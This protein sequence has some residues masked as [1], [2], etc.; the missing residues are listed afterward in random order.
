M[1]N[2]RRLLLGL[3]LVILIVAL[4]VTRD[5]E[6]VTPRGEGVV[7]LETGTFE[8]F[9]LPDYAANLI[10]DDYKSYLVEVEPGIKIHVL[11]VGSGYPVYLQ[12]GNPTSGFLYRKIA[13][14]LEDDSVR[15]IMP[16]MAG[17]GFS[18]KVPAPEHTQN[19][20]TR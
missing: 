19:N 7:T 16:T 13:A 10:S 6:L 3:L 11:E 17:L 4:T 8:A 18:S 9:P 5:G 14:E 20:H 2:I 1:R 12:H 15:L